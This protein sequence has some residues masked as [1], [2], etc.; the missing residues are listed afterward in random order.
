MNSK[1]TRPL[2]ALPSRL[3]QSIASTRAARRR[4]DRIDAAV[5]AATA[6]APRRYE[7]AVTR[8]GIIRST[9]LD[10]PAA[11]QTVHDAVHLGL[12]VSLREL[13]ADEVAF[14]GIRER[15]AVRKG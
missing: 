12:S 15:Q 10:A 11:Q 14:P 9:V 7:V 2:S 6:P 13:P 3:A 5:K 8:D 4:A 1:R